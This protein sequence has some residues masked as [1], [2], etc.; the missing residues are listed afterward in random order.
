MHGVA[1]GGAEVLHGCEAD[2]VGFAGGGFV[3]EAFVEDGGG[4]CLG[5][6]GRVR[7]GWGEHGGDFADFGVGANEIVLVWLSGRGWGF[8]YGVCAAFG[9]AVCGLHCCDTWEEGLG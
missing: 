5:G 9:V 1:D 2:A 8:G 6:C 7:C 4:V 3:L